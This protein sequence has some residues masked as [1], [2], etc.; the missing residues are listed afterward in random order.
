MRVGQILE[1]EMPGSGIGLPLGFETARYKANRHLGGHIVIEC[2]LLSAGVPVWAADP[3]RKRRLEDEGRRRARCPF[4]ITQAQPGDA[5][6]D[7]RART[8]DGDI[9]D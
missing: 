8:V 6:Q 5:R 3:L 4:G 1:Q 7:G 9:S 2:D